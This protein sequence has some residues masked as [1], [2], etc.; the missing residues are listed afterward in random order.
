MPFDEKTLVLRDDF[1]R[2]YNYIKTLGDGFRALAQYFR[3]S[4]ATLVKTTLNETSRAVEAAN[5]RYLRVRQD[6]FQSRQSATSLSLK[7]HCA[8]EMAEAEIQIWMK[9]CDGDNRREKGVENDMDVKKEGTCPWEKALICLGSTNRAGTLHLIQK[10][11]DVQS[12]EVKYAEAV[13]KENKG[14]KLAQEMELV[15][16]ETLQE[17]EQN[18]LLLIAQSVVEQVFHGEISMEGMDLVTPTYQKAEASFAEGFEKKGKDLLAGLNA[19]LFKQQSQ[20][21]EPGMG[22]MEAEILGLPSDV[23]EFRDKV[24]AAFSRCEERIKATETILKF[25]EEIA[26]L[27]TQSSGEI[28]NQTQGHVGNAVSGNVMGTR[29]G[30]LWLAT[31]TIFQD[32]AKLIAD[33]SLMCKRLGTPRMLQRTRSALK[34]LKNE[35]DLDDSSWKVLCDSA[36]TEMKSESKYKHSKGQADKARSRAS[37]RG[38]VSVGSND[39]YDRPTTLKPENV[40]LSGP[41]SPFRL[42]KGRGEIMKKA[43]GQISEDQKEVKDK[44]AF[45]EA[46]ASKKNATMA[47]KSYTTNRIEKLEAQ[48]NEGWNEL[49][50]IIASIISSVTSLEEARKETLNV[51]VS[52]ATRD[53]FPMLPADLDDWAKTVAE[54]IQQSKRTS[55]SE[56]T[57]ME[58]S[59][60]ISKPNLGNIATLFAL[61]GSEEI[62]PQLEQA[63][64]A[65]AP[66][67]DLSLQSAQS[68]DSVSSVQSEVRS[69]N[70]LVSVE[71]SNLENSKP[72]LSET[73]QAGTD[74]EGDPR[75]IEAF[76]KHFWSTKNEAEQPPQ[77]LDIFTCSYRAKEKSAFLTPTLHGRCFTTS[78]KLY[79]LAWDNKKFVLKLED[80]VSVEFEKGFLGSSIDTAVAVTY[81]TEE[82]DSLFVLNRLE[83]GDQTL[84]HLQSLIDAKKQSKQVISSAMDLLASDLSPVPPDEPL[85][86]MEVVISK[87]IRNVSI[88]SV[89]E[90]IW[91]DPAGEKSFYGS[92]LEDEECFD[93]MV[94]DWE[95]AKPKESFTNPWCKKMGERYSHKRLVTF[96]FKRTTHLYI[97]PPIAFVKQYHYLRVEGD[98]KI[99]LAI[100][101]TVEGIPYSDAF[102]IEIR[103]IGSRE[104]RNDVKIEVGLFVLFKTNTMLK[105]QI[106][107]G[108]ISETKNVHL[109]LFNAV[110]RA[111]SPEVTLSGEPEEEEEVEAV[112][113]GTE[114]PGG[115]LALLQKGVLQSPLGALGFLATVLI[116]RYVIAYVF[117]PS[118]VVRLEMQI[119]QLQEEIQTLQKSMDLILKLLQEK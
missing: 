101:A 85:R 47:Y 82:S 74:F 89:Y 11:K 73:E 93:I 52:E 65:P 117:G 18:R 15:A 63:M 105:N 108:T 31:V 75:S 84:S 91:E 20:S 86:K 13:D 26:E 48:D 80:I 19:G 95:I 79:F 56:P 22:V 1:A 81:H 77:I 61:T 12:S 43:L 54:R 107:S 35:V 114:E 62:I 50:G 98:D 10:L 78:D 58:Y 45:E 27:T 94:G 116:W 67:Q 106:K 16:L 64:S 69:K 7:Y 102:G 66:A 46:V 100:E 40:S 8:I 42:F 6:C 71:S 68:F 53:S 72:G 49:K 2:L 97:G 51:R 29:T 88:V 83:S 36:R 90:N 4:I 118:D 38:D 60:S 104:G 23:G 70:Q 92:W 41:P 113:A 115:I 9:E 34:Y 25:L 96:K 119:S 21:Y 5:D 112:E 103:W 109:R 44:I 99:V 32:E 87:S 39:S 55:S 3:S 30:Q 24:K 14:V 37:S 110:K 17:T 33:V 111:C 57:N 76:M 59:L 28:M